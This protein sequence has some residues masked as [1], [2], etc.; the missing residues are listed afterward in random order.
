MALTHR[1][2]RRQFVAECMERTA[3]IVSQRNVT[4]RT[5]LVSG[6]P[7]FGKSY[8]LE[9]LRGQIQQR[10]GLG[11]AVIDLDFRWDPPANR[12]DFLEYLAYHLHTHGINCAK[13]LYELKRIARLEKRLSKEIGRN[14]EMWDAAIKEATVTGVTSAV[15]SIGLAAGV[16]AAGSVTKPLI[17]LLIDGLEEPTRLA[18]NKFATNLLALG[19]IATDDHHLILHTA[20]RITRCLLFDLSQATL[21]EPI[22]ILIDSAEKLAHALPAL[23]STLFAPAE[24]AGDLLWIIGGQWLDKTLD[25]ALEVRKRVAVYDLEPF[26]QAEMWSLAEQACDRRPSRREMMS[27]QR[28]TFGVPILVDYVLTAVP[29]PSEWPALG[30]SAP[31]EQ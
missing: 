8:L 13:T 19:S 29:R 11:V 12:G 18:T 14:P 24:T 7:G 6:A 21:F 20:D 23:L 10:F 27:L 2:A 15:G 28:A 30:R 16:P 5:T 17:R 22:V 1:P 9:E 3:D 4:K 26:S 31:P 25:E